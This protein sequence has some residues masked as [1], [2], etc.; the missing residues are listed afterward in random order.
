MAEPSVLVDELDSALHGC[1]KLTGGT[2]SLDD[3]PPEAE[4]VST[5]ELLS[6]GIPRIHV[7]D[8]TVFSAQHLACTGV[9]A[10]LWLPFSLL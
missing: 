4:H 1:L 9:G 8:V 5:P 2:S 3:M 10:E 6:P 7:F